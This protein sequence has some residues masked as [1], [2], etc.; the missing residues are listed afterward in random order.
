MAETTTAPVV[1]AA[2]TPSKGTAD[3]IAKAVVDKASGKPADPKATAPAPDPNAGKTKHVVEGKE[4][5]LT[6]QQ[7]REYIDK[8]IA[9]EPRVSQLGRLQQE[10]KQ[11]QDALINNP[12]AVL[13]NV[14]K[15]A[16]V[17]IKT[18]V[19]R[20]LASQVNDETK[21]IVGSWYY[22]NVVKLS[23]MT[24]EQRENLEL[25]QWKTQQEE[26]SKKQNED[27]YAR[28]NMARVQAAERMLK[29]QLADALKEV[30]LVKN[31][32][33][34]LGE[35]VAKRIFDV[36]RMSYKTKTPITPKAAAEK[37]Q[38]E[39]RQLHRLHLDDKDEDALIEELGKENAEKVRKYFLKVVK[40]A[41]KAEKNGAEGGK[42]A[43]SKNERQT[44]T[45]DEFREYLEERKRNG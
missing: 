30:T 39:L 36:M 38:N 27:A 12:G 1:P 14:A 44:M 42:R 4:F 18:M 34:P 40:S 41:E 16:N 3:K 10:I 7:E 5:W 32:D 25:K 43:S 2:T 9:F 15:S 19:E 6:P 26:L 45:P 21:E 8:G 13:A 22:D 37:V 28:E 11:F 31:L 23:K 35:M 29:G 20:V 24:D 33:T 17:P